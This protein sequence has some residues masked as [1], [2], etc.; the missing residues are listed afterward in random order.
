MPLKE[1]NIY[2]EEDFTLAKRV[3]D[4][5]RKQMLNFRG[6]DDQRIQR[7]TLTRSTYQTHSEDT[8]GIKI[9]ANVPDNVIGD[10]GV[11]L[12]TANSEPASPFNGKEW[13][14]P[15]NAQTIN[16]S[17][18]TASQGNQKFSIWKGFTN[19]QAAIPLGVTVTGITVR[20][21][22]SV[23]TI[24]ELSEAGRHLTMRLVKDGS[25]PTG[26]ARSTDVALIATDVFVSAGGA[27]N[28][29]G[30]TWAISDFDSNFGVMISGSGGSTPTETV[31]Q[32]DYIQV[33]VHY[34]RDFTDDAGQ[35]VTDSFIQFWNLVGNTII[36]LKRNT[37]ELL[38]EKANLVI[39]GTLTVTPQEVDSGNTGA[40]FPTANSEPGSPLN[41]KLWTNPDNA[42][43]NDGVYAT[44]NQTSEQKFQTWKGF[45]FSIPDGAIITGIVADIEAKVSSGTSTLTIQLT[46]DG[47][48]VT[49]NAKVT[50]SFGTSDAVVS[51]GSSTDL[52]DT[53]WLP[54][55]LEKAEFGIIIAGS[56]VGSLTYS[57]DYIKITIHYTLT[58]ENTLDGNILPS[59]DDIYAIGA[60][61][62][63]YSKGYFSKIIAD[64]ASI[65]LTKL[66]IAT[67]DI[68]LANTASNIVIA[69]VSIPGGT[70]GTNNG[71]YLRANFDT[72]FKSLT[73]NHTFSFR[74]KY[75]ATILT[76]SG[77]NP[78]DTD[79]R[80]WVEGYVL[81]DGAT[82][83][84]E[85]WLQFYASE[86]KKS[87]PATAIKLL[88]SNNVGSAT[89]DST[90][91]LSIQLIGAWSNQS[92][93]NQM[94]VR[95]SIIH[96]IK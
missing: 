45:G 30:T 50:P 72:F 91:P 5:V 53:T 15:S 46:K 51:S 21:F 17:Y 28:L 27:N 88:S 61:T 26:L 39:K 56:A 16:G 90:T 69:S 20:A 4:L 78:V 68:S 74:I 7:R 73:N 13:T 94:Q 59:K 87:T 33:T 8:E 67:T 31:F 22:A 10:T 9:F 66:N 24:A 12:P 14:N 57:I 35:P 34:I 32:I 55:D 54:E 49:G 38:I 92:V 82:N 44:A 52:W 25:N 1:R 84:Q 65:P 2:T 36:Y 86:N 18:A 80:G 64:N 6:L 76:I 79:L 89:E 60:V 23:D 85:L 75:G 37:L 47:L 58:G 41:G 42:H 93:N 40:K 77:I 81:A 62:K 70:L 83:A 63:R 48:V 29:W 3:K 71:V 96:L 11:Y 43:A 95:N 19:L